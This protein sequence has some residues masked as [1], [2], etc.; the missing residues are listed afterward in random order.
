MVG[1]NRGEDPRRRKKKR[2]PLV[3]LALDKTSSIPKYV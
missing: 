1:K 3:L 2:K